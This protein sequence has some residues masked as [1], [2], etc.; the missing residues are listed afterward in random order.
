MRDHTSPVVRCLLYSFKFALLLVIGSLLTGC[1]IFGGAKPKPIPMGEVR[2]HI[3]EGD[4]Y[5]NEGNYD[6]AVESY[7]ATLHPPWST[8][9]SPT[10]ERSVM[11]IALGAGSAARGAPP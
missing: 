5:L 9:S 6:K 10:T 1:A 11:M 2:F 7:V 4:T 3:Q 8:T